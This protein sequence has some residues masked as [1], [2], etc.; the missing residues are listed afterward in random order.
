M[1][2]FFHY[3]KNIYA[4]KKMTKI[5]EKKIEKIKRSSKFIKSCKTEQKNLQKQFRD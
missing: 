3:H 5:M 4:Y 2:N 1:S